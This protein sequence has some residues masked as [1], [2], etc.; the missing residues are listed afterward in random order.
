MLE[1]LKDVFFYLSV[2]LENVSP[3]EGIIDDY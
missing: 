3:N 2:K 1:F